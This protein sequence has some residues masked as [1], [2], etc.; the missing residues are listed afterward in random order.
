MRGGRTSPSTRPTKGPGSSNGNSVP[1][2]GSH[3]LAGESPAR[4]KAVG[5]YA[6]FISVDDFSATIDE[7][8]A[9]TGANDL[10]NSGGQGATAALMICP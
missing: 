8:K 2:E 7:G 5:K 10:R 9:E 3:A 1:S 6:P 4:V